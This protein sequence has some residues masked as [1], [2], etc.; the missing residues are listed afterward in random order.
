MGKLSL[1][2]ATGNYDRT[3]PIADGRVNIEGVDPNHLFFSPEEMFYRA[4]RFE[5]FDV[6]ELSLSSYC[7]GICKPNFPYIAIPV[8]LSR[9]FRHSAIYTRNDAFIV[10]PTDLKGK[11]LGITEYQLTANVW[12]RGMLEDYYGIPQSAIKWV[13]GGLQ[14]PNRPEK[15]KISMPAGVDYQEAPEG[16]TLNK[17]MEAKQIDGL[18][19]PRPPNNFY[20]ND[21]YGRLFL[22][23]C[24]AVSE[25]YR[26]T[27]IF[28]IMH[29]L[30]IKKEL[31][32]KYPWLPASLYKAFD[33]ARRIALEAVL[34]TSASKMTLP[35]IDEQIDYVRKE[36]GP[37]L[38]TYG[39]KDNQQV[40]NKFLEYHYNQGLSPQHL[41]AK[42][43]FHPSSIDSFSL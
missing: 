22:D 18:I 11:T 9:S 35:L 32:T 15:M 31:V 1:T 23:T 19:G 40:I 39:F 17:L 12:V 43:L 25:Y 42:E 38:W 26:N 41:V 14:D 29:V 13:R 2:I 33:E 6:C 24:L 4:F 30:G 27:R 37:E 16:M 20:N 21:A 10:K 3:Q 7:I 36:L 28:P 34:D 5:S 8:F